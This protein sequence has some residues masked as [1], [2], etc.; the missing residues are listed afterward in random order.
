LNNRQ[1]VKTHINVARFS[2]YNRL[3]SARGQ[4]DA[5]HTATLYEKKKI[6]AE[7]YKKSDKIRTTIWRSKQQKS[8]YTLA[9]LRKFND[10]LTF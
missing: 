7:F 5:S 1:T 8:E 9:L 2:L 6:M 10:D 3:K 4:S